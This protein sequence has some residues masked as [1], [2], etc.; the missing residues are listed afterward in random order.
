MTAQ[1]DK[2]KTATL[3]LRE[4]DSPIITAFVQWCYTGKYTIPDSAGAN[5][6]NENDRMSFELK[7]YMLADYLGVEDLV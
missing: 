4:H 2:S 6:D 7:L 1:Q 3:D 5:D